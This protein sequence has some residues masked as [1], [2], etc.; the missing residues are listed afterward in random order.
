MSIIQ[1]GVLNGIQPLD[2]C[3]A[4]SVKPLAS[5]AELLRIRSPCI[6][7]AG[8]PPRLSQ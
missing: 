7:K 2:I 6:E 5:F 1:T 8:V 4:L 3:Q